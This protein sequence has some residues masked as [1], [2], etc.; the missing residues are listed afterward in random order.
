MSEDHNSRREKC[1]FWRIN[2]LDRQKNFLEYE[3][4]SEIEKTKVQGLTNLR[5]IITLINEAKQ[6]ISKARTCVK[7]PQGSTATLTTLMECVCYT[8]YA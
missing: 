1:V 3:L 7:I 2:W 8:I 6:G 5:R 4:S